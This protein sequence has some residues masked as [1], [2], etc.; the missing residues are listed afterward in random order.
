[1]IKKSFIGLIKPRIDY[2]VLTDLDPAMIEVSKP[3]QVK[4]L[5][6][7]PV[8]KGNGELKKGDLLKTGQLVSTAKDVFATSPVTGIVD[9]LSGWAGDFG[10][11]YTSITI[12]V[13]KDEEF[14]E[15]FA[16]IA[17]EIS[18]DSAIKYLS[19]VP[20]SPSLKIFRHPDVDIHTII[21][22]GMD[23]DI[24]ITTNQYVVQSRLKAL[25]SGIAAVGKFTGISSI[26][27]VAPERLAAVASAAGIEVKV[28]GSQY[29]SAQPKMIIKNLFGQV[30]PAGKKPENLGYCFMSAEAVASIGNA[31]NTGKLP[32]DKILTLIRKDGSTTLVSVKIG[33]S[34]A[35]VFKACDITVNDKDQVVFGGPLTGSAIYSEDHPIMPDTN[36]IMVQDKDN[37][38]FVSDYPCVNCG[39]C[40][41][42]CPAR[43]QVNMVVRLLEA[44]HYEEAA[45][46]YDL[47]SCIECGLCSFVCVARIPIFQYIR[48]AKYELDRI[49]LAEAEYV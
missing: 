3:S 43:M 28:V 9:G 36:A 46:S 32:T 31:I 44:G 10:R 37:I 6:E 8:E 33:T 14:D 22:N 13:A 23:E 35:D 4:L 27:L 48:L 39:E 45:S 38:P 16:G 12:D 30:V 29:P 26:V 7:S 41:R 34:V 5:L 49:R 21:V 19:A 25:K 24:W 1:M 17:K 18:L 42:I 20:G 2:T 40:I 15:Q 11:N 47:N